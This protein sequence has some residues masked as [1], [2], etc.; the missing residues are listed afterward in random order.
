MATLK[1]VRISTRTLLRWSLCSASMPWSVDASVVCMV[2]LRRML[3]EEWL[4]GGDE[5]FFLF[6]SL[7]ES[8]VIWFCGFLLSQLF[9]VTTLPGWPQSWRW[10]VFGRTQTGITGCD[11]SDLRVEVTFCKNYSTSGLIDLFSQTSLLVLKS[12]FFRV[13]TNSGLNN[14]VIVGVDFLEITVEVNCRVN[15]GVNR[16]VKCLGRTWS[17]LRPVLATDPMLKSDMELT[18]QKYL[19]EAVVE[20]NRRVNRGVNIGL[21]CLGR[22]WSKS[23]PVLATDPYI[24]LRWRI[25]ARRQPHFVSCTFLIWW[26]SPRRKSESRIK[27]RRAGSCSTPR[28]TFRTTTL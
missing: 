2:S 9:S 10:L 4:R 15:R 17:K 16:G 21:K 12:F 18:L 14:E 19:V 27:T 24:W 28:W 1:D 13:G 23:R 22:T 5:I 11:S 26:K 25:S 8:N 7:F 3:G 20:V 6:F